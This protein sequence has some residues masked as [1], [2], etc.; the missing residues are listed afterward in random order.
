MSP[1]DPVLVE[2][3]TTAADVP[4]AVETLKWLKDHDVPHAVRD[5][6]RWARATFHRQGYHLVPVI[7]VWAGEG[8][9]RRRYFTWDGNRPG[10]LRIA[11]SMHEASQNAKESTA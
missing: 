4:A 7:V 9:R 8:Q 11:A 6:D 2:V 1:S 10:L 5:L 3:Y